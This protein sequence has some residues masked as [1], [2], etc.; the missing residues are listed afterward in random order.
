MLIYKIVNKING[1][2][3]VGQT[4]L[5][6]GKRWSAHKHN[7]LRED[8]YPNHPLYNSMRKHGLENFEIVSVIRCH[9]IKELNSREVFVI[10]MLKTMAPNGYNLKGG[11]DGGGKH[12][13]E[14]KVKM[15]LAKKGK[16]LST[17]HRAKISA[18]GKGRLGNR[19]GVPHSEETKAIIRAKCT[20][21]PHKPISEEQKAKIRAA[22]IGSTPWNKG[23]P[24]S[25]ESKLKISVK[26][27][28][29]IP[30]NKGRTQNGN[31]D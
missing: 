2:A 20:G 16:S 22:K 26:T 4:T 6:L 25:K 8:K 13:E 21:R 24:H 30:W 17:K 15:S 5:S 28:G 27:K 18:A 19:K 3:Y 23:I 1:K 11:G 10:K 12:C 31:S 29:R 9:S 7:L 14:A